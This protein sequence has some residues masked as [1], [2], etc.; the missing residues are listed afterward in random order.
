MQHPAR[1]ACQLHVEHAGVSRLEVLPARTFRDKSHWPTV[2]VA[3]AQLPGQLWR[4]LWRVL[5]GDSTARL[6]RYP[7]RTLFVE[8]PR[9]IAT[10]SSFAS[11]FASSDMPSDS[12]AMCCSRKLRACQPDVFWVRS[13]RGLGCRIQNAAA[14]F[15]SE[16]RTRLTQR[17]AC[18]RQAFATGPAA[19]SDPGVTPASGGFSVGTDVRPACTYGAPIRASELRVT[20]FTVRLM[21][22]GFGTAQIH[23]TLFAVTGTTGFLECCQA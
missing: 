9:G 19:L 15:S 13:L 2:R 16:P 22:V 8:M 17:R 11:S 5:L 1:I 6:L 12:R 18:C 14:K 21:Q 23:A 4:G 7:A 10:A 20:R 3:G